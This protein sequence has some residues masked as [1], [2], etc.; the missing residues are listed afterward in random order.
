MNKLKKHTPPPKESA[1]AGARSVFYL[2]KAWR[3]GKEL[4]AVGRQ[5]MV[6]FGVG[7]D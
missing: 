1:P 5:V 4:C 7:G 6:A 2:R 3:P